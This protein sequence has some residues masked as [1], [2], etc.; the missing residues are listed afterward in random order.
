MS[1]NLRQGIR[2]GW[3]CPDSV[4]SLAYSHNKEKGTDHPKGK[5]L[6]GIKVKKMS[7][8]LWICLFS[9]AATEAACSFSSAVL[10]LTIS[11]QQHLL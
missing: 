11:C 1:S 8:T 4:P 9:S 3:S 10:S 7:V 2:C 5:I 6:G